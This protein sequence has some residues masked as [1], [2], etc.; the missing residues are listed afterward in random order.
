MTRS[1]VRLL[2][3]TVAGFVMGLVMNARATECGGPPTLTEDLVV[4]D[5]TSAPDPLGE[6]MGLGLIQ[7]ETKRVD[8]CLRF[9]SAVP[10]LASGSWALVGNEACVERTVDELKPE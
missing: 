10:E 4:V 7:W 8:L 3:P 5:G 2:L 6:V 1:A 9:S